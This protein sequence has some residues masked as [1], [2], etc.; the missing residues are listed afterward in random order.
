MKFWLMLIA[1]VVFAAPAL[2]MQAGKSAA[3]PGQEPM[4]LKPLPA[5]TLMDFDGKAV[6]PDEFKGNIVVLDFWATWCGPCI[7]EI[8]GYNKLQEK[9]ASKG[10]KVVGVTMVSGASKEVKPFVERYKMKYTILM[11]DDEQAY[12]FNIIGFPTTYLVTRDGK[13]FAKYVGAGP[14]KLTRLESDIQKLLADSV[15]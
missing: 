11:G 1:V 5:L 6:A 14:G 7:V 15:Q 2:S 9:Y 8:P 12:E 4:T 3:Y 10:V 13:I